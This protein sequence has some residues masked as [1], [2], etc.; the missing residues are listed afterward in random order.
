MGS[1]RTSG[2]PRAYGCSDFKVVADRVLSH[3]VDIVTQRYPMEVPYLYLKWS[4]MCV[5]D[6]ILL[7]YAKFSFSLFLFLFM[8]ISKTRD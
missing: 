7:A 3:H 5:L 6:A 1:L 8:Y 2:A 4:M